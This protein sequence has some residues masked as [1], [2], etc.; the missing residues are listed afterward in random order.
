M[1]TMASTTDITLT[2]TPAPTRTATTIPGITAT[3]TIPAVSMP[4]RTRAMAADSMAG[5]A[6]M[7]VGAA[8]ITDTLPRR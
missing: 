8:V 5:A 2:I 1:I 3:P 7:R 4:G 6:L